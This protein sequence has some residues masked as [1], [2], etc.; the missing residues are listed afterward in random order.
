MQRKRIRDVR[1]LPFDGIVGEFAKKVNSQGY[2]NSALRFHHWEEKV[3][4]VEGH[5]FTI[6]FSYK[7]IGADTDIP[8]SNTIIIP[9]KALFLPR[10]RHNAD[11][12]SVYTGN[13]PK[14][15]LQKWLDL[16]FVKSGKRERDEPPY[17]NY[18]SSHVP[19]KN[20][21]GIS[22][23]DETLYLVSECM[24][25]DPISFVLDDVLAEFNVALEE[26]LAE[27]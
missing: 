9:K 26:K 22:R 8:S 4:A 11:T 6:G 14:K 27:F 2:S 21:P 16:M 23:S 10:Y 15:D 5:K 24:V 19:D 17:I 13:S 12:L 1:N 3:Y 20:D 7:Q 18:K 25:G